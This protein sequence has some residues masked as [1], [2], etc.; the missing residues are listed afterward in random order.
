MCGFTGS[1]SFNEINQDK[2]FLSNQLIECRGPDSTDNYF[3]NIDEINIGCIFNRLSILDLSENANQPMRSNET[4]TTLMFNGEIYNHKELRDELSKKGIKFK[5]S[6]SDSETVLKG[7]SLYGIDFIK[8]L[9][10]QFAI[11]FL[12][13]INKKAYLVRDRVGQKP[14]YYYNDNKTLIFSSSLFPLLSLNKSFK[15]NEIEIYNYLNY[16]VI[17]SPETMFENFYKV[18][19]SE[20]IEF[21]FSDN[22]INRKKT[23]YWDPKDFISNER[24]D[25]EEFFE[26]FSESISLRSNADVPVANFLSGGLDSTSITKN[27]YDN[28]ININSFSIYIDNEQ[29]DES[30]YIKQVVSKYNTEHRASTISSNLTY[31]DINESIESLDEPYSDPSVVPS[32]ILAKEI[33]KHYKVAMSGDGGDEL[34]GGYTRI[35]KSLKKNGNIK[36]A[37]SKSYY[38]YPA[39]FG[40]GNMLLSKSSNLEMRYRSFLE[41]QKLLKLL[42]ISSNKYSFAN[43]LYQKDN[44]SYKKLLL[45]DYKFYLSEMMMLKVD[46]TSMA[47][48]LEVRS[49]FVDHKLIEYIFSRSTNYLDNKKSKKILRDYLSSDFNASFVNRKKQGFV[50]DVENWV[51]K[52]K[53]Y[54]E[55]IFEN[56]SIVNNLNKNILNLLSIN[57]SRINGQRIWKL[58]ILEKYFSR[59]NLL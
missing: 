24:F 36:N 4:N 15:V 18:S 1:I 26:I 14:L 5:T 59:I 29:Y 35:F 49:P 10:G 44:D 55:D 25:R 45:A 46:R 2:L 39:V 31:E 52:N 42:K 43:N 40:T 30:H 12:D 3:K 11:F 13:E 54:V 28:G 50:F 20:I 27:L 22:K 21:S 47:N 57:K 37:L 58:F 34:L 19:P 53:E 38:L 23:K 56:G 7:L 9:R 48:S 6:H 51:Y 16:G 41:D 32:F 17:N 8:K 33:S